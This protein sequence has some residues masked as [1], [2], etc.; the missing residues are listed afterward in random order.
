MVTELTNIKINKTFT[1]LAES[2]SWKDYVIMSIFIYREIIYFNKG[3]LYNGNRAA[4]YWGH[5]FK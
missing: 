1:L 5:N 3:Q 2:P 4:A